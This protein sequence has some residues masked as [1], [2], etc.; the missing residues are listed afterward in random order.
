[1]AD[2][3]TSENIQLRWHGRLSDTIRLANDRPQARRSRRVLLLVFG[4]CLINAFDLVFTVLG[5]A[6]TE[7]AEM[8]PLAARLIGNTAGLV[9]FK[10]SMVAFGALILVCFRKRLFT[11]LSCWGLCGVY[12]GLAGI[13]WM[14]YFAPW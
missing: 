3:T 4:L 13:W 11:E 1:M 7:F 5:H 2:M 9:L 12:S 10:V 6:H 8:N 14:Y